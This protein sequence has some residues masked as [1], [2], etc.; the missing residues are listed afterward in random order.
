[1]KPK[2]VNAVD[3]K[4]VRKILHTYSSRWT[5][6]LIKLNLMDYTHCV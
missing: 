3:T 4:Q 6:Q 2:L 1:V 5:I